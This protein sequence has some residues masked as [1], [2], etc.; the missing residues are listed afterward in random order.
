M[1]TLGTFLLCCINSIVVFGCE[2]PPATSDRPVGRDDC[3]PP[4]QAKTE[5]NASPLLLTPDDRALLD[6]LRARESDRARLKASPGDF[7]RGKVQGTQDN[8]FFDSRT[9]AKTIEFK[10]TSGFDVSDLKGHIKFSEGDRE[11]GSVPF[12]TSEAVNAGESAVLDVTSGE[13]TGKGNRADVVIDSVHVR[14]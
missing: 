14:N 11:L 9:R 8:G 1:R 4:E 7:I 13:L 12:G 3:K 5:D 6:L 10:N 2:A